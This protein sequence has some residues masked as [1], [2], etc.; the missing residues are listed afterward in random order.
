MP[1]VRIDARRIR[2]WDTFHD[3]FYHE[4]GFPGWYG[5]N[6]DAWIDCM[7]YL[8]DPESGMIVHGTA[9]DPVVLHIDH[10]DSLRSELYAALIECAAFVNWR[11]TD[12]GDAA[13]LCLSFYRTP[14]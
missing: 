8:D 10:I 7:S 11:R 6:L 13:I 9:S 4:F 2:D 3:V 1:I 5:R 14:R 12:V